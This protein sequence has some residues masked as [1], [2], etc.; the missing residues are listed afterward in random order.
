[1]NGFYLAN[2]LTYKNVS[3]VFIPQ[4]LNI[5]DMKL[6]VTLIDAQKSCWMPYEPVLNWFW[7]TEN[8]QRILYAFFRRS[9]NKIQIDM[10][11]AP[12]FNLARWSMG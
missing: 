4:N 8:S 2:L 7:D 10:A 5:I 3:A 11:K 9:D 12:T 1:M 6:G